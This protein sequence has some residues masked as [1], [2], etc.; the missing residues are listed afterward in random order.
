MFRLA[1]QINDALASESALHSTIHLLVA[2]ETC[3]TSNRSD[4]DK[5]VDAPFIYLAVYFI[6]CAAL[7][8]GGDFLAGCVSPQRRGIITAALLG[9]T[10]YRIIKFFRSCLLN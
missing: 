4:V 10:T 9:A 6:R 2:I 7:K 5:L 3:L 1:M 8:W